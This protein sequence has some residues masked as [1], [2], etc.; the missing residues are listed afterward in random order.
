MTRWIARL[1]SLT[2]SIVPTRQVIGHDDDRIQTLHSRIPWGL[3]YPLLVNRLSLEYYANWSF[4]RQKAMYTV[5]CHP[6]HWMLMMRNRILTRY[7][8]LGSG[9][10]PIGALLMGS[11]MNGYNIEFSLSLI[12]LNSWE[13]FAALVLNRYYSCVFESILSRSRLRD[14]SVV[15]KKYRSKSSRHSSTD[16]DLFLFLEASKYYLDNS[17]SSSSSFAHE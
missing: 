6:F 7:S 10:G 8:P 14:T 15:D 3:D 13:W 16:G 5:P 11:R 4:H 9:S 17:L 12:L 1:L 2:Q